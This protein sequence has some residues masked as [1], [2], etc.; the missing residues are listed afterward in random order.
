[1]N[2]H[3]NFVQIA[4]HHHS[5]EGCQFYLVKLREYAPTVDGCIIK[6]NKMNF[7]C[8]QEYSKN[9]YK[10]QGPLRAI[11]RGTQHFLHSK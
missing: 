10:P 8:Y 7:L 9:E 4:G 2:R 3:N 11:L 6:I 5:T 1:M